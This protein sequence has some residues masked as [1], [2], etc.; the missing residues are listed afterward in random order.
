[1]DF[2]NSD[3]FSVFK[4]WEHQNVTFFLPVKALLGNFLVPRSDS[5]T[6]RFCRGARWIENRMCAAFT[7]LCHC[8][9]IVV[10]HWA[11][12]LCL[13]F[14]IHCRCHVRYLFCS[15]WH[16]TPSCFLLSAIGIQTK[17]LCEKE[18]VFIPVR[19]CKR[20]TNWHGKNLQKI[21]IS[22]SHKSRGGHCISLRLLSSNA[23][24]WG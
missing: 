13:Y 8:T 9:V 4:H 2:P 6:W 17:W 18:I 22:F 5:F 23:P 11:A 19:F 12:C 14:Y 10:L 7:Q 24:N 1:M 3:V 16:P 15:E 20:I 21:W